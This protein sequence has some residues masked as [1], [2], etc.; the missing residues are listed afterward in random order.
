MF[1]RCELASSSEDHD[2]ENK[3]N[4]SSL[5][6]KKKHGDEHGDE[7]DENG[8]DEP[9]MKKPASKQKE[10]EKKKSKKN[11]FDE[12]YQEFAE[13]LHD[14]D[15]DDE[16][17]EE[18][19][20]APARGR[21]RKKEQKDKK[22]RKTKE[23]RRKD[24]FFHVPSVWVSTGTILIFVCF[25]QNV[26]FLVVTIH[27]QD[28]GSKTS[29]GGKHK[30]ADGNYDESNSSSQQFTVFCLLV[31]FWLYF[32]EIGN[33]ACC[34]FLPGNDSTMDSMDDGGNDA[35][36]NEDGY[37]G[38]DISAAGHGDLDLSECR[39]DSVDTKPPVEYPIGECLAKYFGKAGFLLILML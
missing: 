34:L 35:P 22:P 29:K 30:S 18:Q 31:F 10:K 37:D 25:V 9:G 8:D 17:D 5:S 32:C 15:D 36:I 21:H 24:H 28:R 2:T 12:H 3:N 4:T 23:T 13:G 27:L 33:L 20:A 19:D 38:Y 14:D 1:E 39:I 16:G 26:H 6:K 11:K 7:H